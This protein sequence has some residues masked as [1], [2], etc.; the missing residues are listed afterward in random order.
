MNTL[1]TTFEGA[2]ED[3]GVLAVMGRE[4]DTKYAWDPKN[5]SEVDAARAQF[6]SLRSKGFMIFKVKFAW[7]K[8][9]EAKRF[10]QKES[11]YL[12][13]PPAEEQKEGDGSPYRNNAKPE[14]EPAR[15]FEPEANRYIAVAPVGGG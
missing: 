13:V 6:D 10:S 11:R 4:G 2:P 9:A 8:G 3:K 12:F 1:E 15:E 5:K 7:R 14:T